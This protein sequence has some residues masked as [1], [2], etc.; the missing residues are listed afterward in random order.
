MVPGAEISIICSKVTP[1]IQYIS[2]YLTSAT[3][4]NFTVTRSAD[5]VD[6][7]ESKPC[8]AIHYGDQPMPGAFNMFASGLMA[9]T[10][11][12]A[13]KP[14]VFKNRDQT[15]I[16]PAPAGFE[17]PFDMFSASFLLLSRYEEYLPFKADR[18][19]RF[20]ASE[21]L[22]YRCGFLDEPVVDQW[23]EMLKKALVN[24]FKGLQFPE[25]K[26]RHVA[27]F[28]VDN[29]WAY[30]HKG[31]IR[32][33]AGLVKHMLCLNMREVRLRIAVLRGKTPD[34]F[35]RYAYI[36]TILK[37]REMPALFFFLTGNYGRYDTNHAI[38]SG[39][40]K[41]LIEN[42]RSDFILGIHPSYR[43]NHNENLLN[44]EFTFYAGLLGKHP[45]ISRQHFLILSF[46]ETYRRLIKQGIT[47]DY[48]MGYAGH[49]GFRAGTSRPFRFYDLKEEHETGLL[50]H[51]F[52]VMDVTLQQYLR[53]SPP[54]AL[55]TIEKLVNKIKA[56]NGI[57]TSLWHNESLSE[58]GEW[59]GWRDVFEKMILMAGDE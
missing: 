8:C 56:V 25:Q 50:L 15:M 11:I 10:G 47:G 19:G 54:E 6:P 52:E 20:E 38:Q 26:F 32:S 18:H 16:F 43:S 4:I 2:G 55:Q 5:R 53:L 7:P 34:P 57:F 17:L 59:K 33:A 9:E 22:A 24:R 37:D 21:S 28:D 49:T 30:L 41:E 39:S 48:S 3:G 40:F 46:P 44:S 35:D 42:L 29:P 12:N 13:L 1:R 58:T 23:V 36:R 51:P 14:E 27:T 31:R 45:D